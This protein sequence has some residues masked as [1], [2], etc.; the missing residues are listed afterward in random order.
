MI[1]ESQFHWAHC[2]MTVEMKIIHR[3]RRE[4]KN[5]GGGKTLNEWM[6]DTLTMS[7]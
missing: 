4:S 1:Y 3:W 6:S 2:N 5:G 7:M